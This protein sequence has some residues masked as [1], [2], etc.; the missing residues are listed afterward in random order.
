MNNGTVG[1]MSVEN[2]SSNNCRLTDPVP[3]RL[4]RL[5]LDSF[6]SKDHLVYERPPR[7]SHD[8]K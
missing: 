1:V 6:D 8:S 4:N 5:V 2:D 3:T 7:F